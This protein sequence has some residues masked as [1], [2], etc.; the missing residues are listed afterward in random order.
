MPIVSWRLEPAEPLRDSDA[1]RQIS[2]PVMYIHTIASDPAAA[3]ESK[4][5]LG[6]RKA[7]GH[8]YAGSRA[9]RALYRV[10]AQPTQ[11]GAQRLPALDH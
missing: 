2:S 4:I 11:S 8:E 3:T 7:F 9:L 6:L 5:A 10:T 1:R